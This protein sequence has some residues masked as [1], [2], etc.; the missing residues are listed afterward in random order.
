MRKTAATF[1]GPTGMWYGGLWGPT[2]LNV[3]SLVLYEACVAPIRP[4][5]SLGNW[6]FGSLRGGRERPCR[7]HP[8]PK[9]GARSQNQTSPWGMNGAP[10]LLTHVFTDDSK[11]EQILCFP[12]FISD[13]KIITYA[14]LYVN[15]VW[16]RGS[17]HAASGADDGESLAVVLGL[18]LQR[19]KTQISGRVGSHPGLGP[20]LPFLV[21][22][23]STTGGISLGKPGP[24]TTESHSQGWRSDPTRVSPCTQN[25]PSA[26]IL[27]HT[28]KLTH[29]RCRCSVLRKRS[30]S[31]MPPS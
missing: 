3:G 22:V 7:L 30:H 25:R 27:L 18:M 2:A 31:R 15:S 26:H 5:F 20:V 16:P 6:G 13:E 1:A 8:H 11:S 21:S 17:W 10:A 9:M 24:E 28:Q 19:E 12:A 14:N 4:L 23:V 29:K